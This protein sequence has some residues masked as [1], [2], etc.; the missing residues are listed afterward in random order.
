[1]VRILVGTLLEI[2]EGKRN[3]DSVSDI[4]ENKERKKAGFLAP[5]KGLCLIEVKY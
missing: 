5:A 1:M 4:L 3:I 2:G